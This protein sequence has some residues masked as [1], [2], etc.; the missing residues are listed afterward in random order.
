MAVLL[1]TSQGDLV[2][3]LHTKEC[4]IASK[5]FIKLCKIKAYNNCLFYD[6]QKD[7]IVQTGDPTN[8]GKGGESVYGKVYGEQVGGRPGRPPRPGATRPGG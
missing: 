3:D 1:E 4:P 8:T 2:I 5:N 6:V 7:F